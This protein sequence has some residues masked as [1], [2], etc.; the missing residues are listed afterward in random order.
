MKSIKSLDVGSTVMYGAVIAA[1]ITFVFG[2]FYWFLGWIFGAQ[3][4]W[5]DMNLGN[6]TEFTLQSSLVVFWKMIVNGFGGAI[7]GLLVGLLYN[8]VASMMGGI[9]MELE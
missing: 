9:K 3:A 1:V 4:W 2:F 6:W 7:A 8:A 5:I